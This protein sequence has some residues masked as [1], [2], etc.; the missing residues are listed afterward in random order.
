MEVLKKIYPALARHYNAVVRGSQVFYITLG[1][2]LPSK[3][4]DIFIRRI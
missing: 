2:A 1:L 3:D 4:I